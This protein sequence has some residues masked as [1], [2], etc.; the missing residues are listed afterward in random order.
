MKNCFY[1][2]DSDDAPV[3]FETVV[4]IMAS[5]DMGWSTR[6]TGRDYSSFNRYDAIIGSISALILGFR[7]CNRKFKNVAWDV[8]LLI[9]IAG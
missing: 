7:T 4:Q 8:L 2:P 1:N 5:Y 3:T 6:G 9:T